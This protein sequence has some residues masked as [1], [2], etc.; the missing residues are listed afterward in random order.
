[1]DK[2]DI[3]ISCDIGLHGGI[4]FFDTMSGSLLS[5][6]EI[7]TTEPNHKG[8]VDLERLK[9]ILEIPEIHNESCIV[10]L[11][12]IHAFGNS[13][14]G[15]G[16]LMEE[17]GVVMGLALGLGYDQIQIPPKEWQKHFDL[18]P[19]KDLKGSTAKK[20]KYLRRKWLKENSVTKARELFPEWAQTKFKLKT[21]DG[22][23]DS[24]L[25]GQYILDTKFSK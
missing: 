6:Y 11:E 23:S 8:N 14:F 20:T 2:Y 7:P 16:K 24:T 15:V 21:C 1:M 3:L 25:L 4:S 12:S 17:K 10:V 9:F 5:I 22:L 13:G 18:V 19:P